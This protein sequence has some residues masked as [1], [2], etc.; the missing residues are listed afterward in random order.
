[1]DSYSNR[2]FYV[3]ILILGVGILFL[4]RLIHLQIFDSSLK[5]A[6]NDNALRH[7]VQYPARGLIYDRNGEL[8]VYNDAVYDIMVV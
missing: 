6:A 4:V 7:I 5:D 8:L 2:N 3:K 1:M